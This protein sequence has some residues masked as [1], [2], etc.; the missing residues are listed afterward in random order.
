LENPRFIIIGIVS[1]PVDNTLT[2]GPPEI[3]PNIADDIMAAWA[4]PPRSFRVHRK[5]SFIK[6]RP[7]A[8]A[9]NNP[10]RTM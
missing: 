8:D 1:T 4:G 5:A 9:P 6:E 10:P 3:V 2:T 7:P